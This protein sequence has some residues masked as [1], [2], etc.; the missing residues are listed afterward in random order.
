MPQREPLPKTLTFTHPSGREITL[1]FQKPLVMG[2]LNITPDSFSDGGQFFTLESALTQALKL[3]HEGAD[4]LDLGAETTRPGSEP[5]PEKEEWQRLA[6]VLEA[7]LSRK[8][9]PPISVDTYKAPIAEKAVLAGASIINDI[10]AG[11]KDPR[12]FE[13]AQTL[14]VPLILMHMQGEPRNM[15]FSPHYDDVVAEVREFLAQRAQIAL[16][17]GIPRERIILDPGLGFGKTAEHNLTLL[18][19]FEEVIPPGFHSL[20]ALSR[21]AFL[22]HILDGA[23]PEQRDGASAI[24][25]AIAILK[26]AEIVRVHNVKTTIEALAVI[27]AIQNESPKI[28]P[29]VNQ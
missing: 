24:A 10:Y 22:G 17:S 25:N 9:C 2:I 11:R 20:M 8:D 12:I 28:S 16:D 29:N 27:Q 6:P 21:K 5:T 15:Q 4:I 18:N 13:V 14:G 7:L 26:G 19:H 23:S 3:I 1:N